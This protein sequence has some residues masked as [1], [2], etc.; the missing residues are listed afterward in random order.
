MNTVKIMKTAIL[1]GGLI[2]WFVNTLTGWY[3]HAYLSKSTFYYVYCSERK[4][5]GLE[6]SF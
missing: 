2:A 5:I 6:N 1:S 3:V 4:L